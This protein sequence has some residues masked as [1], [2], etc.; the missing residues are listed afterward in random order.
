[1]VSPRGQPRKC[2][3]QFAELLFPRSS[4]SL[5]APHFG[6]RNSTIRL[7]FVFHGPEPFRAR[8]LHEL[9][10]ALWEGV[11]A[12]CGECVPFS[13]P[14]ASASMLRTWEVSYFLSPGVRYFFVVPRVWTDHVLPLRLSV[15]AD[16]ERVMVGR[17]ELVTPRQRQLLRWIAAGPEA[18]R[19]EAASP[20]PDDRARPVDHHLFL[21]LGRFRHA[22]LLREQRSR[23]TAALDH[24][25]KIYGITYYV[26]HP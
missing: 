8:S 19:P 5:T 18:R 4:R 7:A 15:A 13:D 6:L 23:P 20:S 9:G 22:L 2:P 21:E 24:F 17:V 10:P 25:M 16:V 26:P 12:S 11:S 1:M 3:S 14:I